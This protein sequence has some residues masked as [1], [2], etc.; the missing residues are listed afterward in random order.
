MV[1]LAGGTRISQY[2]PSTKNGT[3][4]YW[5]NRYGSGWESNPPDERYARHIG[6]E[7]R[8]GHQIRLHPEVGRAVGDHK[9]QLIDN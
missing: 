8:G 3:G 9:C 1:N 5:A 7:D 2:D 4:N 6:F